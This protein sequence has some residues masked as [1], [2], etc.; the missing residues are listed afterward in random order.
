MSRKIYH[1]IFTGSWSKTQNGEQNQFT[2]FVLTGKLVPLSRVRK[3]QEGRE[4]ES[5]FMQITFHII[6]GL[7]LLPI[8]Y[9]T[10]HKI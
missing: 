6:A 3:E 9:N 5:K 10:A 4:R 8:N 2:R 1:Y 7:L